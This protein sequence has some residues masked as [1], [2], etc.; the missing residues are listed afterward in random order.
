MH[1]SSPCNA[2][3]N[4]IGSNGVISSYW[5]YSAT[6][7]GYFA[8][9]H[10]WSSKFPVDIAAQVS[11]WHMNDTLSASVLPNLR[12]QPGSLLSTVNGIGA[13]LSSLWFR[14]GA[15]ITNSLRRLL[16]ESSA[17]LLSFFL[18]FS[19]FATHAGLLSTGLFGG[20]AVDGG[21]GKSWLG[22]YAWMEPLSCWWLIFKCAVRMYSLR[23]C[24]MRRS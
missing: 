20:V 22:P 1:P 4:L 23:A 14:I 6:I 16:G 5:V 18:L 8:I 11:T 24:F 9:I 3:D 10:W 2:T 13:H 7:L 19:A 21:G 17:N 15:V 12:V